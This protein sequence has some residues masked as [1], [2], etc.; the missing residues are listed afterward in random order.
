[1]VSV[2]LIK[3]CFSEHY[4]ISSGKDWEIMFSF[5]GKQA[6]IRLQYYPEVL[7]KTSP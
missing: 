5:S 3:F 6:K 7:L 1:M 2:T 4:Q